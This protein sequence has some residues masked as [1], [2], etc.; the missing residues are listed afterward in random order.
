MAAARGFPGDAK[1]PCRKTNET[2]KERHQNP[3]ERISCD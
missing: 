3:G 1:Y 2:A